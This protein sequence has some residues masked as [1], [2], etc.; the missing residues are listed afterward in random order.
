[1]CSHT[2]THYTQCPCVA[3]HTHLCERTENELNI[4]FCPDYEV[5]KVTVE[6]ACVNHRWKHPGKTTGGKPSSGN[7]GLNKDITSEEETANQTATA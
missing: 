4:L 6:G 1:M 7:G 2:Y 3:R 5:K